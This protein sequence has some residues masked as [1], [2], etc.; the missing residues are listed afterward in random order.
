M[1]ITKRLT[2][3]LAI[4]LSGCLS[5]TDNAIIVD[6]SAK[7]SHEKSSSKNWLKPVEASIAKHFSK[8]HPGLTFDTEPGQAVYATRKGKVVVSGNKEPYGNTI[9]IKHRFGFYTT[10]AHNQS[11]EVGI[12]DNI[13]KGQLI[14]RTGDT[15][16]YF[17]M[18]KFSTFINPEKYL[19]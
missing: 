14:A 4:L 17:A 12:G 5:S 8:Q 13:A 9:I 1:P 2:W 10:Y 15:A 7:T 3:I 11:L 19:K 6:K 18:K 16:F